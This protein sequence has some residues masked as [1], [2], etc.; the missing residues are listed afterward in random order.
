MCVHVCADVGVFICV[1]IC[2]D[3]GTVCVCVYVQMRGLYVWAHICRCAL[4][5]CNGRLGARGQCRASSSLTL[6]LFFLCCFVLF[7]CFVTGSL[8]EP[9]AHW[10]GQ[11]GWSV[12][13]RIACLLSTCP[14]VAR[15]WPR[16]ALAWRSE[17]RSPWLPSKYSTHWATS[18]VQKLILIALYSPNVKNIART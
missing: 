6:L 1:H 10:L 17:L 15:V 14:G 12:V 13:S 7:V 9:G 2:R 4:L 8:W 5:M 3:V 18:P 11:A 16:P